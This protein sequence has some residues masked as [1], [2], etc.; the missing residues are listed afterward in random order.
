MESLAFPVG[1][2]QIEMPTSESPRL[3]A[4]GR[5]FGLPTR[6]RLGR[7]EGANGTS[8]FDIRGE[9]RE[10]TR[11]ALREAT[12]REDAAVNVG[13][14][15]RDVLTEFGFDVDEV[16]D[17]IESRLDRGFGRRFGGRGFGPFGLSAL[18]FADPVEVPEA[19][20]A[21]EGA[22]A[23]DEPAP[24]EL[25]EPVELDEIE[26]DDDADDIDDDDDERNVEFSLSFRLQIERS[27]GES[28]SFELDLEAS[29][30]LPEADDDGSDPAL[31]VAT[32]LLDRIFS[33][34]SPGSLVS[35]TA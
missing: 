33:R 3:E 5:R 11:G 19:V 20:E 6:A 15:I 1:L 17:A 23:A 29:F 13:N 8:L 24:V 25:A 30:P 26:V 27:S 7:I 10:A 9:L 2:P 28:F 32:T 21:V 34:F 16:T 12:S 35:T 18:P 22:T 4:P 31:D 14:A